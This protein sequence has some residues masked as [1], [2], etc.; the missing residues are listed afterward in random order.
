MTTAGEFMS[1]KRAEPVLLHE[2][3][4]SIPETLKKCKE[5]LER[6]TVAYNDAAEGLGIDISVDV[7]EKAKVAGA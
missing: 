7:D 2:T 5:S 6:I 3:L 1:T 4:K